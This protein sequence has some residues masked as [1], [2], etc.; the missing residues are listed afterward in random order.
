LAY[1]LS[2]LHWFLLF[3]S[4]LVFVH[5]LGHFA[6]AKWC[7]VKVLKFSIGFG[8]RVLAFKR[9]DT[10]YALSL[11][12]LGGFVK[13]LGDMPG[14]EIPPEEAHRAF[15]NKKVWQRAA[16]VAAGPVFNFALALILYFAMFN[17]NQTYE[18]TRIGSVTVNGPAWQGG[19]R[20]GDKIL[21]VDGKQPRDYLELRELVGAKP[22]QDVAI[23]YERRGETLTTKV[24]TRAHDEANVFQE[25]EQ[26]G[27]IEVNNR[28]VEPFVAVV[29]PESPAAVAGVQSG[30]R[31]VRVQGAPVAA[32]Y[33]VREAVAA[34]REGDVRLS[35][36]R[37]E[38]VVDVTLTPGTAPSGIDASLL[39]AADAGNG[40]TG[41]VSRECTLTRVD[42]DTPAA[43]S[44]LK[45][46]DRVLALTTHD[47]QGNATTKPVHTYSLDLLMAADAREAMTMTI[48]RGREVSEH[49]VK[50]AAREDK[51]ELKN[52]RRTTVFGAFNDPATIGVY[53][54]TRWIGPGEAFVR[55]VRHV[56]D[57]MTLIVKGIAKIVQ[58]D[59][60]L[61]NMGGPI[62]LFVIAEKSAKS[63]L[64]DFL[65][66]VAVI[67]V[68]LGLVNLVPVPVL[69]GGHL[70][71]L[72]IEA[73]RRR[74]PSVRVRE[75]ANVVGL[76]MLL[77]LMVLVFKNDIVR[78]V[79]G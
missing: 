46:G 4:I 64:T 31:I 47:A 77:M 60:P 30:D 36:R 78:F 73:V 37:G 26:R 48:Q 2:N 62:M 29:D 25:R 75:V 19:L 65:T 57:D 21:S 28:F 55:A 68:N 34:V 42:A 20:P 1:V 71:F 79:L 17:G 59:I 9:G 51:D 10:E 6:L 44:G 15:N 23:A 13:M 54:A 32:W 50:L 8:P 41:L 7:G 24:H 16:I 66:M 40:Y 35:V 49:E 52:V 38:S 14:A 63:G 18:D 53:T 22:N 45:V 72:G 58:G 61:D 56:G 33:D 3:I 76:V 43:I 27:R 5:E 12:P 69:D 67:S 39:S 70:M 11:L 74:P